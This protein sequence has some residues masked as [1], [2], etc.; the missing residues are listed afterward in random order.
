MKTITI[1]LPW[2][3]SR[4]SPN[5]ANGH[6]WSSTSKARKNARMEAFLI[7]KPL[8]VGSVPLSLEGDL[9]RIELSL[10]I[11]FMQPDRRRRDIDGL[12]S[13]IKPQID[14]IA[15]ALKIDDFRFNPVRISRKY[16]EKPGF[17]IF[18]IG[19]QNEIE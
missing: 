8:M 12:L 3:D 1:K 7:A 15:D 17:V 18:E 5:K 6:H 19:A 4:I 11:T 9:N 2:P 14:G 16:G 13:S 10:S